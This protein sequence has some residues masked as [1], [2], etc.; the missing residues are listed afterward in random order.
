MGS[1]SYDV[2]QH[3]RNEFT[4]HITLTHQ[5]NT[6]QNTIHRPNSVILHVTH[7]RTA[8]TMSWHHTE[9]TSR[10][11]L[12]CFLWCPLLRS[13]S[14]ALPHPFPAATWMNAYEIQQIK[15]Q[16][17]RSKRE[18]T[19]KTN[20]MWCDVMWMETDAA[21]CWH[22]MHMR[23]YLVLQKRLR[24]SL[25]VRGCFLHCHQP[26]SS[27]LYNT[28]HELIYSSRQHRWENNMTEWSE[29]SVF[30]YQNC[31]CC[32]WCVG[33]V[34]WTDHTDKKTRLPPLVDICVR[35]RYVCVCDKSVLRV[36]MQGSIWKQHQHDCEQDKERGDTDENRDEHCTLIHR[37]IDPRYDGAAPHNDGID[38]AC[39]KRWTVWM[40]STTLV[41]FPSWRSSPCHRNSLVPSF[42]AR[43]DVSV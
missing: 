4:K 13:W 38:E 8:F 17:G 34:S 14:Q 26:F 22:L 3:E 11:A 18:R 31:L 21:R 41:D 35:D 27:V 24:S 37:V 40:D 25:F 16:G 23:C 6:P 29:W 1:V 9:L 30:G 39:R 10:T 2:I 33:Q 7:Q 5:L 12:S 19:H 20:W 43:R 15:L 28:G 42:I 32:R 36:R